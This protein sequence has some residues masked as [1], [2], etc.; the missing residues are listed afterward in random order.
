MAFIGVAQCRDSEFDHSGAR[1]SG[2]CI[3]GAE[4]CS[5][6]DCALPGLQACFLSKSS[7][8]ASRL[9]VGYWDANPRARPWPT[10]LNR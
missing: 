4:H 6:H 7:R 5:R 2:H 8:R 9:E 1:E 3:T 10:A